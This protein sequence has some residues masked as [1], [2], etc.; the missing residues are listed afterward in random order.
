MT[1]TPDDRARWPRVDVRD[2]GVRPEDQ[3][4][5]IHPVPVGPIILA[6]FA[7]LIAAR[8]RVYNH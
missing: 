4:R 7:D 6:I 3:D 8:D 2:P 5:R 1:E